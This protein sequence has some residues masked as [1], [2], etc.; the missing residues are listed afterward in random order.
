MHIGKFYHIS[1]NTVL[2]RLFN[3]VNPLCLYVCILQKIK[4][5]VGSCG[6]T[7]WFAR[8]GPLVLVLGFG[9]QV[10]FKRT[11]LVPATMNESDVSQQSTVSLFGSDYTSLA[12]VSGD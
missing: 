12:S 5:W 7:N 11:K 4:G 10:A 9:L 2:C 8:P 1:C 3:S 6:R